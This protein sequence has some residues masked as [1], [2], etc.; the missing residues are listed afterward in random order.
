MQM[1]YQILSETNMSVLVRDAAAPI[2]DNC[3]TVKFGNVQKYWRLL[4][5]REKAQEPHKAL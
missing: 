1:Y 5:V 3:Y 2:G 4:K